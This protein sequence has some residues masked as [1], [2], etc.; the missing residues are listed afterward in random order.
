M[1]NT[2]RFNHDKD[3]L[4]FSRSPIRSIPIGCHARMISSRLS[5]PSIIKQ[6]LGSGAA[7][8]LQYTAYSLFSWAYSVQQLNEGGAKKSNSKLRSITTLK[9]N[10]DTSHSCYQ[11]SPFTVSLAV[12][13]CYSNSGFHRRHTGCRKLNWMIKILFSFYSASPY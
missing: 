7:H 2:A 9:W 5:N 13:F 3:T 8:W 10:V 12:Q 4:P 1:Q 6:R 11:F